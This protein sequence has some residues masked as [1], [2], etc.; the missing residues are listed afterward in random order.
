MKQH[1]TEA[2]ANAILRK[3]VE[4]Q[5]MGDEMSREQLESIAAEIGISPEA[6]ARAEDEWREEQSALSLRREFDAERRGEFRRRLMSYLA[7]NGFLFLVNVFTARFPWVIFSVLGWGLAIFFDAVRT[8]QNGPET[9]RAFQQWLE[10]R[11]RAALPRPSG[12]ETYAAPER[13]RSRRHGY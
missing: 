7:V 5:P 13:R 2:E 8:F 1:F 3:A 6:L 12:V 9:D 4:R 10:E 11:E